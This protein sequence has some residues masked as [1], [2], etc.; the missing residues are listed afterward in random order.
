MKRG[1]NVVV[2]TI[3]STSSKIEIVNTIN[4]LKSYEM[5]SK[6][7]GK[8]VNV[9]Y[10]ENSVD[11][12]RGVVDKNIY[13]QLVFLAVIFSGDNKELDSSDLSNMLNYDR[14]TSFEP[15]LSALELHTGDIDIEKDMHVVTVATIVDDTTSSELNV[16]V[17][18]QAVGYVTDDVKSKL[19]VELPLHL[20]TTFGFFNRKINELESRLKEHEEARLIVDA[21]TIID[22]TEDATDEGLIL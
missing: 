1:E 6:K 11:R 2:F 18:Y 5:I 20:V 15:R 7:R 3:G 4:T 9:L 17:E 12:S 19:E 10:D 13:I 21:K 22:N 8:A 14:V 16:P